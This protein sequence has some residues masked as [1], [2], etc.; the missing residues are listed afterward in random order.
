MCQIIIIK[1][2]VKRQNFQSLLFVHAVNLLVSCALWPG[3]AEAAVGAEQ[4]RY[5]RVLGSKGGVVPH[6]APNQ[7]LVRGYAG[8][9]GQ[10][11]DK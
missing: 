5:V 2:L 11:L 4:W 1:E 3:V 8:R 10:V 7:L 9:L 6:D